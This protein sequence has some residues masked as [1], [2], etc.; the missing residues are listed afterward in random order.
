MTAS[1]PAA[2]SP[3]V[4]FRL[5]PPW[6]QIA[7]WML[8]PPLPAALWAASE[9][10]GRQAPAWGFAVLVLVAWVSA[11]AYLNQRAGAAGP[12]VTVDAAADVTSGGERPVP[13][14]PPSTPTTSAHAS[15]TMPRPTTPSTASPAPSPAPAG[16]ALV[17]RLTVEPEERGAAYDRDLFG[18]GWIDADRDGCDTRAEVLIDESRSLAQ[19][20]PS[21]CHV[22]AGDWVSPYDGYA[23]ADPAELE[24]DHVVALAEAWDSGASAWSPER[25][26]AFA[27]DVEDPDGLVAVTATTN[28]TKSDRDPASWLPPNR[29]DR[30]RFAAAWTSVKLR[31]GLSA[32][33]AEVAALRDALAGC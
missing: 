18:A 13:G 27:N 20:D 28:A 16:S 21:G 4:R 23:T 10:R 30:C 22:V 31:W 7:T 24:I 2:P 9:R 5:L 32:D 14:R 33:A 19:V 8:L 17:D 29:A 3:W 12:V 15:P 1:D 25:R 11:G 26:I 6:G